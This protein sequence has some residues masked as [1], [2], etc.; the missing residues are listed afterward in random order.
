MSGAHEVS[1][2]SLLIKN[3]RVVT[4]NERGDLLENGSVY[5][6][7]SKIVEVGTFP[8]RKHGA[9]RTL[10]AGGN[11]VMPGW[12]NAHH[13]LYSTFARGFAPPGKPAGNFEEILQHLW[14]KL[15]SA[16]T[17]ED[18]YCSARIAL[19]DAVK[20][21]CT[22]VIDHHASPSCRDG[23]LDLIEKAFREAGLNGCLCY[24]VSDRHAEG[25]G[26]EE[27]ARFI[28]KCTASGDDQVT[29]LFGLHA[30]MTLG[31]RTLERCAEARRRLGAG[32]H[33]HAAEDAID[34]QVAE[35]EFGKRVMVRF[36]DA[37]ITGPKTIFVHGVHLDDG[38]LDILK[39]TDSTLVHNPE[40][41]MNNAVGAARLLDALKRGVRVGLGTDGM[42]SDMIAS[43]RAAYLLQRHALHDPRVAFEEACDLLLKNNR[44]ICARLFR[45]PR[46]V[47]APGAQ[48][49]VIVMDY[50]P[51]TPFTAQTFYGHLLFG[52]AK[53][54]VEAT[55]CRGKVLMERGVLAGVD[56][57]G[58][59][60]AC[61]ERAERLWKRIR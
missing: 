34:Q 16:L 53:A 11:V 45:E 32:F 4:L 8:E 57:A 51:F 25:D 1:M 3:G 46:G 2:S 28:E 9:D 36:R 52:L 23:S 22:T 42:S 27:N 54:R 12:I 30:S 10:D 7:G 48:A 49:D 56:E 21:G 50:V 29:A 20:L 26:I 37:G 38:E 24:E 39:E 14:W 61:V 33:V 44:A 19:L 17:A 35:R 40:S 15:D 13:H 58:L 59:R 6:E 18:V 60:A 43:A 5:I 55:V 31:N 47:L 41:N